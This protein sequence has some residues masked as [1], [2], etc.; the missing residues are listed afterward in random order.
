MKKK[1]CQF[2]KYVNSK[3]KKV[4]ANSDHDKAFKKTKNAAGRD[5]KDI[6]LLKKEF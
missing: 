2:L 6:T 3:S 5:T 4:W 1:P